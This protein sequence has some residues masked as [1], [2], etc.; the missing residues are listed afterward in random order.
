MSQITVACICGRTMFPDALKGV[1]AFRC[2]CGAAVRVHVADV[3]RCAGYR[4]GVR[5]RTVPVAGVGVDVCTEHLAEI[6]ALFAPPESSTPPLAALASQPVVYY[7]RFGDRVKIGTSANFEV[8]RHAIPHDEILAVEP[9][10]ELVE[11]A[12]QNQFRRFNVK[13]EWFRAGGALLAHA[14]ALRQLHAEL[15]A[16]LMAAEPPAG[17]PEDALLSGALA[18]KVAGVHQ[19]TVRAWVRRGHLAPAGLDERRHPLYRCSDV[20]A[21][22]AACQLRAADPS[23][24]RRYAA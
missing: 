1:G 9:G 24:W 5:C 20:L 11:T 10:N 13:G 7:L 22:K 4:D 2:G 23:A 18:A 12:R 19:N 16:S 17:I 3:K 14:K 6:R 8:R 15:F 21:T